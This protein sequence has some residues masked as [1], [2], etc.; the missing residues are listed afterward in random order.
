MP[1]PIATPANV[2]EQNFPFLTYLSSLQDLS[3]PLPSL[4]SHFGVGV[5]AFPFVSAE[6]YGRHCLGAQ[7]LL[8]SQ[9]KLGVEPAT[10]EEQCHLSQSVM[11]SDSSG[12]L[13]SLVFLTDPL[14][15]RRG[16]QRGLWLEF[17]RYTT[18]K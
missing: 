16:A 11:L 6:Y 18:G 15:H 17:G 12:T 7:E 14:P 1:A 13:E 9:V 8:T 2:L 5:P 4:M 3:P 10:A